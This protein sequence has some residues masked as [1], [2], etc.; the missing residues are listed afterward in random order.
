VTVK[1]WPAITPGG[2]VMVIDA[3]CELE[4]DIP[5]TSGFTGAY[6]EGGAASGVGGGVAGAM[7]WVGGGATGAIGGAGVCGGA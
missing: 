1:T 2:T 7:V 6:S 4:N 5:V 3:A